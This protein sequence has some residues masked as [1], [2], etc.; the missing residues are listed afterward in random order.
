[1]YVPCKTLVSLFTALYLLLA[2]TDGPSF[3]TALWTGAL[4][5]GEHWA[6][7]YMHSFWADKKPVPLVSDYNEAIS[8]TANVIGMSDL[9]CTGWGTVAVL[10]I[11]GL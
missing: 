3:K 10:R 5:A 7:Q 9:L 8:G 4:C 6:A 1:V 2:S 11:L